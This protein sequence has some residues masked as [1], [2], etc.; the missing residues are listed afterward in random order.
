MNR[1]MI[2]A[3]VS[4]FAS[5]LLIDLHA[6]NASEGAFNWSKALA[7]WIAG[8]LTGVLLAAGNGAIA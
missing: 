7:R 6:F 5:A 1:M 8:G 3:G 2:V 4:G